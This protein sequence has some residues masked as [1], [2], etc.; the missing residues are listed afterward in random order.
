MFDPNS[1]SM[2]RLRALING[3]IIGLGTATLFTEPFAGVL[4]I[5]VGL[6]MEYWHRKR[7]KRGQ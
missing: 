4:F 2:H 3:L 7:I 6:G 5:G 1:I